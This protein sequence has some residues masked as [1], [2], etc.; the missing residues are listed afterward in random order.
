MFYYECV[1]VDEIDIKKYLVGIVCNHI[2]D[3]NNAMLRILLDDRGYV[4]VKIFD[5]NIPFPTL[6]DLETLI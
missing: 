4:N 2:R 5:R 3:I 1:F 6:K